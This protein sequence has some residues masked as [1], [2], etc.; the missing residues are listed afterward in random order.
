MTLTYFEGDKRQAREGMCRLL[1]YLGIGWWQ[2]GGEKWSG[3]KA[4][5]FFFTSH[6]I[7]DIHNFYVSFLH[8]VLSTWIS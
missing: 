1:L 5:I 8:E 4:L 2:R 3:N 6:F 7:P